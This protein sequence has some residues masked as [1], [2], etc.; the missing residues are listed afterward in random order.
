LKYIDRNQDLLT[1]DTDDVLKKVINEATENLLNYSLAPGISTLRIVVQFAP[2]HPPLNDQRIFVNEIFSK[3]SLPIAKEAHCIECG[4]NFEIL[5]LYE[6]IDPNWTCATCQYEKTTMEWGM[7][8]NNN[9][10]MSGFGHPKT[11]FPSSFR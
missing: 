1:I 5:E 10:S 8:P 11:P 4:K 2:T 7:T 9:M 3:T 6:P